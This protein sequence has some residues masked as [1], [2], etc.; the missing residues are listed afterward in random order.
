MMPRGTSESPV[1]SHYFSGGG[2]LPSSLTP[3][4]H[5]LN[6]LPE[7]SD[8]D[9]SLPTS[10]VTPTNN[11]TESQINTQKGPEN[12]PS[13]EDAL[14][15]SLNDRLKN[16]SSDRDSDSVVS[17]SPL[18]SEFR[19]DYEPLQSVLLLRNMHGKGLSLYLPK[20]S[21]GSDDS[22]VENL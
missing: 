8:E 17:N 13:T 18:M 4:R 9:L 3:A 21:L 12:V 10:N 7:N 5:V 14:T 11:K 22:E 2:R 15:K 20:H 16:S 19:K 1:D 6:A